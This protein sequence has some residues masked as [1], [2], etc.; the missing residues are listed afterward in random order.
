ME[1]ASKSGPVREAAGILSRLGRLFRG[2]VR[3]FAAEKHQ[4]A[5][6]TLQ[7]VREELDEEI[8]SVESK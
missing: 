4:E 2:R 3:Q 7:Q 5:G 8:K 6:E 1:Q